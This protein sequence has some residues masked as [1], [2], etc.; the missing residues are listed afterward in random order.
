MIILIEIKSCLIYFCNY[1]VAILEI[2]DTMD[3]NF[4]YGDGIKGYVAHGYDHVLDE[5]RTLFLED[6]DKRS[7]L[8]V[9]VGEEC[10]INLFRGVSGS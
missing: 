7:Q 6:H 9:Y 10:V 5:F 4:D 2:K 1:F 3:A 8:C